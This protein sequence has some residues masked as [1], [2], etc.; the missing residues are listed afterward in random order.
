MFSLPGNDCKQQFTNSANSLYR[1]FF[2]GN[3]AG[4]VAKVDLRTGGVV[5]RYQGFAGGVGC[6][7]ERGEGQESQ[8][9]VTGLDRY[10]RVYSTHTP[11]LL[12]QVSRL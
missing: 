7:Q 5:S 1:C 12:H 3:S 11:K 4:E 10:L 2:I 9:A 8:L 6:I